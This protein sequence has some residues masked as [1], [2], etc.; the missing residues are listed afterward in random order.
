MRDERS[1]GRDGKVQ[2]VQQS[3]EGG[4]PDHIGG[5]SHTGHL[6]HGYKIPRTAEGGMAINHM[7]LFVD[8]DVR[9]WKKR[10]DSNKVVVCLVCLL[11]LK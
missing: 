5:T 10:E 2:G 8:N 9:V 7:L 1:R 4:V 3:L 6:D 11:S